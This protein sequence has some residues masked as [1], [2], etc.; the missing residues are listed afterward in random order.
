MGTR[1]PWKAIDA[2]LKE[3]EKADSRRDFAQKSIACIP[4]LVPIDL[5]CVYAT[6][7]DGR[8]L[9]VDQTFV[10][11]STWF[12]RFRDRYWN[13]IPDLSREE[14]SLVKRVD[15]S[16]FKR[17]EYATDF[18]RPQ[19][20]RY[21]LGVT[22]GGASADCL[23]TLAL[24][25]SSRAR[26]FSEN[27]FRTMEI[28]Q[29]HLDNLYR[30]L[31]KPRYQPLAEIGKLHGLSRR[32][33]EVVSC[34]LRGLKNAQIASRLGLSERTVESHCLHIYNKLGIKDRIGLHVLVSRPESG[35]TPR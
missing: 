13:Q 8:R 19:R 27:D 7:E 25:R 5:P 3:M 12:G 1:I 23:G 9:I 11:S 10:E 18:M 16:R 33:I 15:W 29:P 21:S 28:I 6:V 26:P 2:V 22:I 20:I 35:D 30:L 32:E 17:S 34:L 31:G 4:R 14:G 24:N